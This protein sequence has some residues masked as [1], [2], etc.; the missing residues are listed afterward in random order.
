MKKT[1]TQCPICG[2][3]IQFVKDR[4]EQKTERKRFPMSDER[5]AGWFKKMREVINQAQ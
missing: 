2:A 1:P 4:P 5:A 3:E